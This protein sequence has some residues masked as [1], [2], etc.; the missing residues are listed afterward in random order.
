MKNGQ[1]SITSILSQPGPFVLAPVEGA[2]K[3]KNAQK[4][5]MVKISK[6]FV[7]QRLIGR[8]N[9]LFMNETIKHGTTGGK[10]IVFENL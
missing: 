9:T 10:L 5:V 1:A 6:F 4:Q 7:K 2:K 8:K 3:A